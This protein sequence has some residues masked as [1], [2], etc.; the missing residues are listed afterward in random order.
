MRAMKSSKLSNP[1]PSESNAAIAISAS[2]IGSSPPI[3]PSPLALK[4]K[5]FH[6]HL[7]QSIL[8]HPQ[9]QLASPCYSASNLKSTRSP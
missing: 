7:R 2:F 4:A 9:S 1:S 8:E 6:H 5:P 3:I